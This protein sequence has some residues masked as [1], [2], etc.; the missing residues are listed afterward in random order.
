MS[1]VTY[2]VLVQIPTHHLIFVISF[3]FRY[4]QLIFVFRNHHLIFI[5]SLKF[6][7]YQ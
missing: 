1:S 5:F 6:R 2:R 3:K 7:Y 4:Y